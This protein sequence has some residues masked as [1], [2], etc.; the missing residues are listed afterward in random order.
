MP[1]L[2]ARPLAGGRR[3]GSGLAGAGAAGLA[4]MSIPLPEP[5]R[6]GPLEPVD[7]PAHAPAPSG[8]QPPPSRAKAWGFFSGR[9][10]VGPPGI[11][12]PPPDHHHPADCWPGAFCRGLGAGRPTL[13]GE[14][15]GTPGLLW[16]KSSPPPAS[17]APFSLPSSPP[18]PFFLQNTCFQSPLGPLSSP[19][20]S[21]ACA[22]H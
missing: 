14:G 18:A 11:S 17:A 6:W 12:P 19:F 20:P 4:L 16:V 3:R 13:Q 21:A 10:S 15:G 2:P 22:T 9:R 7:P 5:L 8:S 1:G